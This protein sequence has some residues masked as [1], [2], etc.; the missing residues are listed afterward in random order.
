MKKAFTLAE[1]LITLCIL[2]VIAALTIPQ[3]VKNMTDYTF[4]KVQ[5][6][7]LAKI[8]EATKQMKSN[9][10]L[11]DSYTTNEAFADEF[12]KYMKVTTRCTSANLTK[13]FPAKFHAANGDEVDTSTLKTGTDLGPT[14]NALPTVG[15][16]LANGTS[17]IMALKP[18]SDVS[19]LRI[20]PTDNQADTTSCMS[21]FYDINGFSKPNKMGKDIYAVNASIFVCAG[22]KVGSLCLDSADVPLTSI[23]SGSAAY[24]AL[25]AKGLILH[26]SGYANDYWAGAVQTCDAKGMRLPTQAELI[27]IYNANPPGF[28][29]ADTYW[30]SL[31]H[32]WGGSVWS[33]GW[34]SGIAGSYIPTQNARSGRCVK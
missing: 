12:Q 18:A 23:A 6:N 32:I 30:S 24:N 26:D 19:C 8:T 5:K 29:W 22:T 4:S 21:F 13:C 1:V 31:E 34:S 20:D 10:V 15:L 17:M 28:N 11:S 33:V 25:K 7:V 9:D 3:M 27:A 16:V 2:G 14:N